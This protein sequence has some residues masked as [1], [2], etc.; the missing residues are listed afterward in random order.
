MHAYFAVCIILTSP[1]LVKAVK[2]GLLCDTN[3]DSWQYLFGIAGAINIAI[4]QLVEDGIIENDTIT[5]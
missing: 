4:E 5:R 2:I 3:P 1:Q